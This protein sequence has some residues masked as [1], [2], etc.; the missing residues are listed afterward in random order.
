ME[1]IISGKVE[2]LLTRLVD[3]L[4]TPSGGHVLQHEAVLVQSQGMAQWLR[5]QIASRLGVCMQ[6]SFPFPR[7]FL[8]RTVAQTP[9]SEGSSGRLEPAV[10]IWGLLDLLPRIAVEPGF[11]EVRAYLGNPVD[12]L[13]VYQLSRML[14]HLFDQYATYR[15]D[16][17]RDWEQGLSI[18][19]RHPWQAQLW[20]RFCGDAHGCHP[21]LR[22]QA[23]AAEAIST[24]SPP[25]PG[26]T[27][28]RIFAVLTT[29]LPPAYFTALQA[30]SRTRPVTVLVL[31][32]CGKWWGSESPA[33]DQNALLVACG[34]HGRELARVAMSATTATAIV[35]ALGSQWSHAGRS[36]LH[37]LQSDL[38]LDRGLA[39]STAGPA[40][41]EPAD[42]GLQ[43]LQV[44]AC[45]SPFREVQVLHDHVRH[46]LERDATLNPRDILVVTPDLEAYAPCIESVFAS[47]V[48][49]DQRTGSGPGAPADPIPF[50]IADRV[51]RRGSVV[52]DVFLRL[53]DLA[54]S[55]LAADQV[56]DLLEAEPVRSR[57]GIAENE[58]PRIA[59][60]VEETGIRWGRD[61]EHRQALNLPGIAETT[62]RHGLDQMLLGQALPGLPPGETEALGADSSAAAPHFVRIEGEGVE[63][64]GRFVE[65][66][67]ALFSRLETLGQPRPLDRWSSDLTEVLD[68]LIDPQEDPDSATP[69]R[70]ALEALARQAEAGAVT[71]LVGFR[72]VRESLREVLEESAE[73]REVVAGGMTVCGMRLMRG[74]PFRVVCILGL[75]DGA[76]PRRDAR[77]GF[78][79]LDLERKDGDPSPRHDDRHLFLQLLQ[80]TRERFYLSHVGRSDRDNSQVP[81]SVLVTEFLDHIRRRFPAEAASVAVEHP[82]HAHDPAYFRPGGSAG[83]GS[84]AGATEGRP[85]FS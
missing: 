65:F 42:P 73:M 1:I 51:I 64:M 83:V 11:E 56:L 29:V 24:D 70:D 69:V 12:E 17:I 16:W 53:L 13:K 75:D 84:G 59:T 78:D 8:L 25:S 18:P 44:H 67:E 9:Q 35:P 60:W 21:M 39:E 55:R 50:A 52:A 14:A 76:F 6:V 54:G 36:M 37:L 79:L 38:A 71:G 27:G 40:P 85:W 77:I 30:L 74:V 26:S 2:E 61:A 81:P 82:L 33:E 45:H 41:E 15:P 28:G 63:L 57:F 3:Q 46:W 34:R 48:G 80:A 62:W 7:K 49:R 22:L 20:Q 66:A 23:G 4:G 10:M 31:G 19:D 32:G 72:S 5:L 47:A 43:S 58:L 68:A